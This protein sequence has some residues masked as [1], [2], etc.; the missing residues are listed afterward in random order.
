MSARKTKEMFISTRAGTYATFDEAVKAANAIKVWLTRLCERKGYSCKA[1]IGISENN[2]HTG[3]VTRVKTGKRGRPKNTF[4]RDSGI[5]RPTMTDPHIHIVLVA[6][7]AETVAQ[8]LV[9][10]LNAKYGKRV[11]WAKECRTKEHLE[12]AI[13]YL[14]KQSLKIRYAEIN[15]T[16]FLFTPSEGEET[17]RTE[18]STSVL[19]GSNATKELQ[20]KSNKYY[21]YK[22]YNIKK[23]FNILHTTTKGKTLL[24]KTKNKI[25]FSDISPPS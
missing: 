25:I 16:L 19:N 24:R 15:S 3:K 22:K 7:P 13:N 10:H 6:N 20:C 2:P 14:K 4:V 21:D 17:A 1:T 8:A 18:G 5:M 12:N 9:K 23:Y 11:T